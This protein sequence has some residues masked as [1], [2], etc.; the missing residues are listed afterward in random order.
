MN[1]FRRGRIPPLSSRIECADYPDA[2]KN[3]RFTIKL[4]STYLHRLWGKYDLIDEATF[5][6]L[7]QLLG[8]NIEEIRDY[9]IS[10]SKKTSGKKTQENLYDEGFGPEDYMNAAKKLIGVSGRGDYA[11]LK[12]LSQEKLLKNIDRFQDGEGSDIEKNM[13]SL[14]EMFN[15]SLKEIEFTLFFF[16]MDFYEPAS[17]FFEH[18][19]RCDSFMGRKYLTV[20]LDLSS[21]K[22]N[23]ILSGRLFSLELFE[24]DN[25]IRLNREYLQIIE[26]PCGKTLSKMFFKKLSRKAIPLQKHLI[27][28]NQ[29]QHLLK[30]LQVTPSTSTHILFYGTAGTGKTSYATAL[31]Y[32]AGVETYEIS[33]NEN[34]MAGKKRAAITA[35]LNMTNQGE[36]SLIIVDEADNILNTGGSFFHR[37]ETLDKGWLNQLLEEPGAKFIWIV[38]SISLIEE[39]V[40]RRFAFSLHFKPFNQK[41]RIQLW[42][43]ILRC[44]RVKSL[45]NQSDIIELA[46]RYVVNAGAIDIALKKAIDIEGS[47]NKKR[48]KNAVITSLDAHEVLFNGGKKEI[49]KN[50][51]EK[52]YSLKGLNAEG[53]IPATIVQMEKFDRYLRESEDNGKKSMK[54]LLYGPPGTGK[55]EFARFAGH[56]L[57]R[58]IITK[59]GSDFLNK[60]VGETEGNIRRAFEQAER[61]D[62]ILIIDEVDTLLFNRTLA[63]RS[64]EIS[65]TNELLTQLELYRGFLFCTTN[66]LTGLDSASMR[67]F[68]HKIAFDYLKPEGKVILYN[69]FMTELVSGPLTAKEETSLKCIS[70]LAPGDFKVVYEKFYFYEKTELTH[71]DLLQAL[72][73]ESAMK[74]A[75]KNTGGQ[76]GF[77]PFE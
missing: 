14:Q 5:F 70:Q 11:T 72:R 59:R 48:L 51:I 4:C 12:R 28:K 10:P 21:K 58:E 33:N 7:S 53:D 36:G 45:F 46:K 39:S 76:I 44:N 62:A 43:S 18:H 26:N 60:Y 40:L 3:E 77:L 1:R 17:D 13:S 22:L 71:R 15:L 68:N 42:D 66:R 24:L 2:D 19:L 29:T 37:G 23:E 20:A 47:S 56:H 63:Q 38:N 16:I 65:E 34:N 73:D 50:K 54:L 6:F 27:E 75:N 9:L 55:S 32:E 61:G 35:A 52:N 49:N 64:W 67:R 41:G 8:P 25:F 57:E 31:A 74:N 30:L 69:K